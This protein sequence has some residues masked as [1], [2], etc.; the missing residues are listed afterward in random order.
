MASKLFAFSRPLPAPFSGTRSK[1]VAVSSKY[2][3]GTEAT[4]TATVLKG[5]L[6]YCGCKTG[7]EEGAVGQL[8]QKGVAEYKSKAGPDAFHLA[9]YDPSSGSVL[10]SVYDKNTEM[11][12]TY[13]CNTSGKDGAAIVLAMLPTLME[14]DEFHDTLD[15]FEKEYIAG[16]P[17]KDEARKLGGILCD[18]AYRRVEDSKC[19]AHLKVS[20]DN[21]G[22]VMRVSQTHLD[23]GS[24][25][26][27]RVTAGEFTI[28]AQTG[29]AQILL[30]PWITA[31]SSQ[32]S[33]W[34]PP[35]S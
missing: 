22:N 26:P 8:G 7:A 9:V 31:T 27:D 3:D 19:P 33:C 28:F 21:S 10:A 17:D 24:F 5:V 16:F 30:H 34:I 13:A 25:T 23:S 14:D 32:N 18:N 15:A 29:P 12:E 4:L 35:V 2:G 20:I 11:M 1:K 6:A